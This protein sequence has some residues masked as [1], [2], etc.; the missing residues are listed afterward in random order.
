MLGFVLESAQVYL[1]D[2]K[3]TKLTKKEN[4]APDKK[5]NSIF[6]LSRY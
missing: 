5:S 3:E 6:F 4:V 2:W 1:E